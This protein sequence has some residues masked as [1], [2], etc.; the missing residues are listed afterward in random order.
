MII[1]KSCYF[2]KN[3]IQKINTYS[4]F[5]SN[6]NFQKHRLSP[7]KIHVEIQLKIC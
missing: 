6:T 2:G 7:K 3:Q 5:L 1:K 4:F